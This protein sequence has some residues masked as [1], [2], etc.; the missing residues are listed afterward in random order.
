MD[1]LTMRRY[2][3]APLICFPGGWTDTLPPWM[4]Q[5]VAQERVLVAAGLMPG[6]IVGP[7]EVLVLLHG[8]A[9]AGPLSQ[10]DFMV[11]SWAMA[12]AYEAQFGQGSQEA[13]EARAIVPDAPA[14]ADILSPSGRFSMEYRRVANG[15]LSAATRKT[16]NEGKEHAMSPSLV[17][18][19]EALVEVRSMCG[20]ERG[21]IA[22]WQDDNGKRLSQEE[23]SRV[24]DLLEARWREAQR[25]AGVRSPLSPDERRRAGSMLEGEDIDHQKSS[26]QAVQDDLPS[27]GV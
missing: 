2:L 8:A 24:L 4:R 16:K 21:C 26:C 14:D 17:S 27:I 22:Q 7:T 20:D 13:A 3:S 25:G 6:H 11:F 1:R 18:L 19:V 9:M 5:R 15:I 12:K 10:G 23:R